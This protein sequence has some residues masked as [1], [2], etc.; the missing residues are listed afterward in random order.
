MLTAS[1]V[2]RVIAAALPLLL[3]TACQPVD[4]GLPSSDD[5]AEGAV[6]RPGPGAPEVDSRMPEDL[7][8]LLAEHAG[9]AAQWQDGAIPVEIV[10]E[11]EAG[12]WVSA[13]VV[14]L[15]PDADRFLVITVDGE[16]TD[17]QRP[18][19]ETLGVEPVPEPALAEV[20]PLPQR[21]RSPEALAEGARPALEGC[22][23][24]DDPVTVLYMTGA[25][26][27]WDGSTWTEPPAW[28]ATVSTAEGAGAVVDPVTVEPVGRGCVATG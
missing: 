13:T 24:D 21:A 20:P 17:Q 4:D 14:Y 2:A 19:L 10:A 8:M 3:L 16:G 6:G 12:G 28:T 7:P 27:T 5:S 1:G 15:A 26:A 9:T 23:T 25:P 18:T 22:G 11:L